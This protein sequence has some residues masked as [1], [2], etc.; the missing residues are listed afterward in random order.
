MKYQNISALLISIIILAPT[1]IY[2]QSTSCKVLKRQISGTYSGG[3]KRGLANGFGKAEGIDSYE[4]QF[5]KGYPWGYGVYKYSNG[6]V[7]EGHWTLGVRNG[8]GRLYKKAINSAVA[9]IWYKDELVNSEDNSNKD[10]EILSSQNIEKVVFIEKN[11]A[12]SNTIEITFVRGG[13]IFRQMDD[14]TLT[15]NSGAVL[16]NIDFTGYLNVLFPF[17]GQAEFTSYNRVG[18]NYVE[19]RFK[20][21]INKPGSWLIRVYF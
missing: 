11:G 12:D 8:E 2:P 17:E 16:S 19:S 6:D 18:K 9:G 21:K 7:Y 3:C 14:L 10:F 5:R 13:S 20:F 15:S 1:S 4:G